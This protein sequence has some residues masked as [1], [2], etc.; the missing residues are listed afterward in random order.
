[1]PPFGETRDPLKQMKSGAGDGNRQM[2]KLR[3][4]IYGS[5]TVA[6]PRYPSRRFALKMSHRDIFPRANPLGFDSTNLVESGAGDG[7]RQMAKL[8][9]VIYGSPTVAQPRYPSRRFAL[10]MSHRDIFPRANPLGF[11]STYL[12]KKWSG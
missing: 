5:P 6:Q 4:V 11:D 2:A 7:N 8:R 1:M 3:F 10:K 9:F 12:V